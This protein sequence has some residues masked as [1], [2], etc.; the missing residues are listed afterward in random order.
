MPIEV[1][2]DCGKRYRVSDDKVG[3]RFKCR[4][5]AT[6]VRVPNVNGDETDEDVDID[7]DELGIEPE[8]KYVPMHRRLWARRRTA[9]KD[10]RTKKNAAARNRWLLIAGGVIATAT[11]VVGVVFFVEVYLQPEQ[12]DF[13]LMTVGVPAYASFRS[14]IGK[15]L[16]KRAQTGRSFAERAMALF[17]FSMIVLLVGTMIFVLVVGTKQNWHL[18]HGIGEWFMLFLVLF[19]FAIVL[20]LACLAGFGMY[21]SFMPAAKASDLRAEPGL[22]RFSDD[23]LIC[24]SGI[25]KHLSAVIVDDQAGM[26]HFRRSFWP[27]GFWTIKALPW[28]SCPLTSVKSVSRFSSKG[29]TTLTIHTDVG[30]GSI[31]SQASGFE[32]LKRRFP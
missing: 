17:A 30:K 16:P 6:L 27:V 10:A 12:R 19:L 2:C 3:K 11:L 25:A 5:C 20:G 4:E 18:P 13:L 24:I 22:P 9:K 1:T 31:W 32:E 26:I 21:C 28:F 8:A 23:S 29:A 14:L 15:P 7:E